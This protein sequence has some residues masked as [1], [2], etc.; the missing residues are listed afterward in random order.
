MLCRVND[1][2]FYGGIQR[3]DL[4]SAA[5]KSVRRGFW[6]YFHWLAL[7]VFEQTVEEDNWHNPGVVKY[8]LVA[9]LKISI[10]LKRRT[11]LSLKNSTTTL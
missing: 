9:L 8:A 7:V 2:G 11:R 4:S 6:G 10:W 1:C 5:R 3:Y